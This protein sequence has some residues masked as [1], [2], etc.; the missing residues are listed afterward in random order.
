MARCT[1][2]SLHL[3]CRNQVSSVFPSRDPLPLFL[4]G[5]AP[6]CLLPDQL[7]LAPKV[8]KI[9]SPRE[10]IYGTFG[11]PQKVLKS[12][13]FH[14]SGEMIRITSNGFSVAFTPEHKILCSS[15]S[16]KMIGWKCA[17]SIDPSVDFLVL[18]RVD[19]PIGFGKIPKGIPNSREFYTFCGIFFADGEIR[20]DSICFSPH[21]LED[22]RSILPKLD[23]DFV[24]R[25]TSGSIYVISNKLLR[26]LSS[27]FLFGEKKVVPSFLL[28]IPFDHLC[29][30]T[31]V[32]C[33]KKLVFSDLVSVYKFVQLQLATQ[34]VPRLQV[35]ENLFYLSS[36]RRN[37]PFFLIPIEGVETFFYEGNV[38]DIST[39]DHTYLVPFVV[40]NSTEDS[41]GV[42]FTGDAG[43]VLDR[44]L[45]EVGVEREQVAIGNVVRCRPPNNREPLQDEIRECFPFLK[46]DLKRF[47]PQYII[48]LGNVALKSLVRRTGVTKLLGTSLESE[49]GK[50][51]PCVHPA[52]VLRNP[53]Y[54]N[55]VVEVLRRA[56]S[57][58]KQP[59]KQETKTF[60]SLVADTVAKV[61]K[62]VS[63]IL[64]HP[65]DPISI[66]LETTGFNFVTDEILCFAVTW[67]SHMGIVV[68]LFHQKLKPF[69][70]NSEYSK[71]IELLRILG[72][73]NAPK[74]GH[75]IKFDMNFCRAKGIPLKNVF[76]D[77]M[78]AH[79]LLDEN[80]EHG[81]KYLALKYTNFG[82][83]SAELRRQLGLIMVDESIDA[84][85]SDIP[86]HMLWEYAAKDVA[87][88]Y[89]L[90]DVF[91][92][93]LP[94]ENVENFFFQWVIPIMHM[95]A[96]SEFR[97]IRID[98]VEA[99]VVAH[100]YKNKIEN[101]IEELHELPEV[102][103]CVDHFYEEKIEKIR[104][105][106]LKSTR[107]RA[108]S[109]SFEEY[110][111]HLSVP[112]DPFNFSSTRQL[113]YLMYDVLKL[114]IER[115]TKKGNPSTDS[116]AIE[117]FSSNTPVL[118]KVSEFRVLQKWLSTFVEP[119]LNQPDF[120][121]HTVFLIHGTVT[122]RLASRRPNVQNIPRE[123]LDIRNVYV[124]DPDCFLVQFDYAQAEFRMWGNYAKDENLTNDLSKGLDVHRLVASECFGVDYDSVTKEQRQ[125]A[126]ATVFGIMYGRGPAS[127]ASEFG[128][129]EKEAQMIIR[130]FFSRYP[131]AKQ[132]VEY[133]KLFV[134]KYGYV[135]NL[136][137]R[138]RRL[139][140]IHSQERERVAEA[141]RQSINSP[142]QS[143]ASDLTCY[144]SYAVHARLLKNNPRSYPVL[145]IHDAVVYNI[146]KEDLLE[147]V[148]AIKKIMI[149]GHPLVE[150]PL[151]VE[152]KIGLRYGD[153]KE[154]DEKSL[155]ELS[156]ECFLVTQE[157]RGEG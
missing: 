43:K 133:Q 66:D 148:P 20:D 23:N 26:I 140:E 82:D 49:W 73:C 135:K 101:I 93:E 134:K 157:K 65:E 89:S 132:W 40:H 98:P 87:V 71:V 10:G 55:D 115:T 25:E 116:I 59:Q 102:Q 52:A 129:S 139:P 60:R 38:Y 42:P 74:I 86:D 151:D 104:K 156:N 22:L 41:S 90:Y 37:A 69:W 154:C 72:E 109:S 1:R 79:Y 122:G 8:F 145:W 111:K 100:E 118:S 46:E 57:L 17:K 68:P 146:H 33:N 124:A 18:P 29:A 153:L 107:L 99:D 54:Y 67:N 117:R 119:V 21:V 105:K 78:L 2:C 127:I 137:G 152:I 121:V 31:D 16:G 32:T 125:R 7:V 51:I 95:L 123:A 80:R 103:Q 128:F 11:N 131:K 34:Q 130:K 143:A 56:V 88:T 84:N 44:A 91:R 75:N 53:D 39:S 96:D 62:V 94:R 6:G 50:V 83:Y 155:G 92:K 85:F 28:E 142:I 9:S 36:E 149:E 63:Y 150:V 58:V 45:K 61:D 106:F 3:K 64:E 81:L 15:D 30:L 114:P 147:I 35:S 120:R 5:E 77:T 97:G 108:R 4:V 24:I 141:L 27:H 12:F 19:L 113:A 126:K 138:I 136:F 110:L 144:T 76:F 70:S 13:S 47:N 112:K 14:Y 48:A